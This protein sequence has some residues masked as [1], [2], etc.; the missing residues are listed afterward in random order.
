MGLYV[1]LTQDEKTRTEA[2]DRDLRGWINS[3][4]TLLVQARA[5]KAAA[6]AS[7]GPKEILATLDAGEI[8]PNTGGI[9]GAQ[10]LTKEEIET[11]RSAGLDD[12]VTKYDV[13]II[14]QFFA[15][16][17]GPTAGQ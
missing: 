11:L 15:K 12:L 10:N 16:A 8:I 3:L 13:E 17:A 14:R 9:A 6:D 4:A 2:W 7:G 1:D 5:L